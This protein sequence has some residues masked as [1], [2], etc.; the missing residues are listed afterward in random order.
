[1]LVCESFPR[2]VSLY[3]EAL[4]YIMPADINTQLHAMRAARPSPILHKH[5]D[6]LLQARRFRLLAGAKGP[7]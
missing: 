7:P 1:M 3:L 4:N 6:I 5:H 2:F